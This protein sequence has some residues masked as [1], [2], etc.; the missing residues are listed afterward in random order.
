M[1]KTCIIDVG[2]NGGDF[3]FQVAA[4]SPSMAVIGIEPIP[5]L[6]DQLKV[7]KESLN[8]FN[9]ELLKKAIN[10]NEGF[11]NFH[12]ARH[13]DWGVSSLLNFDSENLTKNEYWSQRSDLYFE[14]EIEVEVTRL[15][16]YLKEAGYSHIDFIKIDAQGVDIKV[17]ESL[18]DLLKNVDA[19]MLEAPTTPNSAL[20][21]NEPTLKDVLIFLERNNFEPYAIKPNDPACAEVNIF[22]NRVGL[23]WQE[24][25]SRLNLRGIPI[26][27]G[28]H[29]WHTPSSSPTD[30]AGDS[31][32]MSVISTLSA[33]NS[34]AWT[35]VAHWQAEANFFKEKAQALSLEAK[36]T[37]LGLNN[38]H[39]SPSSQLQVN[40]SEYN[41]L[42]SENNSLKSQIEA[43]HRSTSWRLTAFLRTLRKLF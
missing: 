25:E 17:L 8:L 5:E 33:E 42:L 34:A 31:A 37:S 6:Y 9:V 27:D 40:T 21:C 43:I 3:L 41:N 7:K 19:G 24:I 26:Y 30:P 15:D 1:T 2:A 13:A 28:K 32:T 16:A 18:G 22:F 4:R 10:T 23:D 14:D 29:Y 11:E 20:Y 36:G 39:Q 12:V 38:L 35:R